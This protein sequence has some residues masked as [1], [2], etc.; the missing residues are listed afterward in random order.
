MLDPQQVEKT[1]QELHQ[2]EDKRQAV[3]PLLHHKL[4]VERLKTEAESRHQHEPLSTALDPMVWEG[5]SELV[6]AG[7]STLLDMFHDIA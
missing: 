6:G 5:A 7:I 4:M 1:L 2:K 3:D